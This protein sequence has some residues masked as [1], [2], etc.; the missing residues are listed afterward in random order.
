M[1]F[2][3]CSHCHGLG[4]APVERIEDATMIYRP[5]EKMTYLAL[6]ESFP[7][8]VASGEFEL[9]PEDLM[10]EEFPCPV[11]RGQKSVTRVN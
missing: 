11:C 3:D 1:K 8:Q 10:F 2:G 9:R 4:K 5:S 7:E 6:F